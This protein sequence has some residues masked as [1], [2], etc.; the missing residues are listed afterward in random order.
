MVNNGEETLGAIRSIDISHELVIVGRGQG[1]ALPL[2]AG[3]TDRSDC[4][5]L[6]AVGDILAS[7]DFVSAVSVLVVQQYQGADEQDEIQI[8]KA[9]T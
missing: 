1:T 8:P 9:S 7:S 5:E 2:L 3:L 6:G 4:P